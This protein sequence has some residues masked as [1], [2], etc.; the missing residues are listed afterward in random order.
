MGSVEARWTVQGAPELLGA[1]DVEQDGGAADAL[2]QH[3]AIELE[4]ALVGVAA[5]DVAE[6]VV[7]E[8]AVA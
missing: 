8:L 7:D 1:H 3:A 4:A 6:G 2:P 5:E